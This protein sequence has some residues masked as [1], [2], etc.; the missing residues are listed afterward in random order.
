GNLAP[1][2]VVAAT[3]PATGKAPLSVSFS[4]AGSVDPDGSIVAYSWNWGD[5]TGFG[6]TAN[7]S[8]TF[9]T[10]GTYVVALTVTD[11]FGATGTATTT[12][13][14]DPNLAPQAVATTATPIAIAPATIS[15]SSADSVDP[16]GIIVTRRWNFGDGSPLSLTPNPTK[17]YTS[18]GNYVVTLTVIDD[19]GAQ[20]VASLNISVLSVNQAPVAVAN[21][22]PDF[23]K[24]P[25]EVAFSSAGSADPDGTIVGYE[26]NFGDGSPTSTDANPTHVYANPGSYT[27]TLTVT[28]DRTFPAPLT[29]TATVTVEVTE[30][31]VPP[32]AA[33]AVDPTTGKVPLPV[34][35]SS[36][37]SGDVDGTI[38][39]YEWDFGD[40]NTSGEADPSHVYTT[41]GTFVA[42][43]TVTDDD[44]ATAMASVSVERVLNIFPTASG[45]T[46]ATSGKG[47]LTVD[48][49]ASDSTDTD[50]TIVTYEWDFD[51]D[52]Q[53][54][55]TDA[56]TS[57]SYAPGEYTAR[58]TV[59][60]D[61][62]D[63]D[64][65]T[66][67]I[68]S[69]A[70]VL[71]VPVANSDVS[72][73]NAPLAVTFTGSSS[74]DPDGSITGYQWDFGDGS[75]VSTDADTSHTYTVEG[76]YSAVLTVTDSDG[77]SAS[78]PLT[79][80]VN[81]NPAPVAAFD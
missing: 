65:A 17:T 2:A 4:S 14:V 12:V 33:A 66:F 38:V 3:S 27:A 7:P 53:V 1:T 70:N 64:S 34:Q 68:V 5:G 23:G 67:E 57:F 47:P 26:W 77:E 58:L 48:F 32:T 55:S 52:G 50:G 20:D 72:S 18:P 54:D 42:T 37:G 75:A 36:A 71:P 10:A 60:D 69:L 15:F 31:N 78:A 81:A 44:G 51:D 25:L 74:L 35:F 21:A 22:T 63:S 49:D 80:V 73:G 30:F 24:A 39:S 11:N 79:I 62:G 61:S 13:T 9:S 19:N 29:G 40:G 6:T 41:A 16:D 43:L 46:S 28:D 59:T 56:I 45:T 8:H 76:I